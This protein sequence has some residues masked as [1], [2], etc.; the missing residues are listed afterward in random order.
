MII[1]EVAKE[2]GDTSLTAYHDRWLWPCLRRMKSG[3]YRTIKLP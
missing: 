3:H 2:G 1:D